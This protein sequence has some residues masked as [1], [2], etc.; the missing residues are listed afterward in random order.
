M[1]LRVESSLREGQGEL[2]GRRT[3]PPEQERRRKR[4]RVN[5]WGIGTE[6]GRWE[7]RAGKG[8]EATERCFWTQMG[9]RRGKWVSGAQKV[10]W[11]REG[12]LLE[13]L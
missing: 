1:I 9:M 3:R 5:A 10:F 13:G 7:V 8:F 2:G 4:C 11:S 6:G 12:G